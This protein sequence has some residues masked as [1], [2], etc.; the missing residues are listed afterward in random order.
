MLEPVLAIADHFMPFIGYSEYKKSV[1]LYRL[2]SKG[3]YISF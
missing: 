1:G 3:M 2:N